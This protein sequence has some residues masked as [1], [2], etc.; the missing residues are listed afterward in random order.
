MSSNDFGSYS[1][2]S[3]PSFSPS[4]PATATAQEYKKE[5]KLDKD[6][7]DFSDSSDSDSDGGRWLSHDEIMAHLSN[8]D[9]DDGY[10]FAAPTTCGNCDGGYLAR[11]NSN[12]KD[13]KDKAAGRSDADGDQLNESPF[14]SAHSQPSAPQPPAASTGPSPLD[15]RKPVCLTEG[16]TAK[17]LEKEELLKRLI[18]EGKVKSYDDF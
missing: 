7:K 12:K 9:N 11:S 1:P 4:A 17:R 16:V 3:P 6:A 10:N 13:R 2:V 14:K 8:V 18:A 15:R 5:N